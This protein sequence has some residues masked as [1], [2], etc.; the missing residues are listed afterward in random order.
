MIINFFI[1]FFVGV[2][3]LLN[4]FE[5]CKEGNVLTSSQAKILELLDIKLACFKLTLKGRWTKD[6]GFEKFHSDETDNEEN[7]LMEA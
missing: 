7:D 3:T 4:N 5:V 1:I 6:V 2:V